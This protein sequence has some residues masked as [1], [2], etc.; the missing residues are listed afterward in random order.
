MCV[1]AFLTKGAGGKL[2]RKNGFGSTAGQI[3]QQGLKRD[4]IVS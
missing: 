1:G 2:R 4:S 3:P